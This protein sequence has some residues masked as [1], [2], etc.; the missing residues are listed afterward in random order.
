VDVSEKGFEDQIEEH[1]HTAHGFRK[2]D[3]RKHKSGAHYDLKHCVDPDLL[4]EFIIATQPDEWRRL[5]EQHGTAVVPKF[6]RRL[7]NQIR[8]RGTL[9][10][11]RN[12]IKDFGCFFDL[13]YFQPATTLNPDHQAKFARN[14][15]SAMRQ[16]QYSAKNNNSIDLV[17]F[18][19]GLP[20]ITIELKNKLTGQNAINAILQYQRTRD[21]RGEPLLAFKRCLVHFAV[22][23]DTVYMT[24]HLKGQATYF[25]PFNR[26]TQQGGAGNPI[27]PDGYASSYLWEEIFAPTSL[28]EL[29]ASFLF[30]EVDPDDGGEKLIFP[31]YH[32]RDAV[33]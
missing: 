6:L 24:T 10:V 21:P 28:L 13:A 19:N 27:N 14:I 16:V 5:E 31:R 15:F 8:R 4:L 25:L 20:I 32:Q 1:L 12:G 2:R 29:I 7:D 11:L 26:G 17:L 33:R 9:H 3:G 30:V 18:L 23:G 22:D